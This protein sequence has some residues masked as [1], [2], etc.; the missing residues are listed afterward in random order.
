[1]SKKKKNTKSDERSQ[2]RVS[3]NS[4]VLTKLEELSY[5]SERKKKKEGREFGL[6]VRQ[7][8]DEIGI[9]PNILMDRIDSFRILQDLGINIKLVES[10]KGR[11]VIIVE[12]SE[13]SALEEINRK[14]D[15][16]LMRNEE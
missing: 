7:F 16:L 5:E 15:L 1:M 12:R 8:A 4:R 13:K 2:D 3:I 14:I 6:S 11:T 10:G 9:H